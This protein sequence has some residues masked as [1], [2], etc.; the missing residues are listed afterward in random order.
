MQREPTGPG[1]RSVWDFPRPPAIE[2]DRRR[3]VVRHGGTVVADTTD[4]VTR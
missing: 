4:V 3:V 2:T 1:Q